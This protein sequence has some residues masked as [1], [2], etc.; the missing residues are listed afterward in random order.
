MHHGVKCCF[1]AL[2]NGPY[3]PQRRLSFLNVILVIIRNKGVNVG[4]LGEGG[5]S[6]LQVRVFAVGG[7]H[8]AG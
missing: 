3:P 2:A 5:V 4:G 7:Q 6:G 8:R 1:N